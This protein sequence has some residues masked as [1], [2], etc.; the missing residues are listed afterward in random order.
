VTLE[1]SGD[2]GK[3]FGRGVIRDF[4]RLGEYERLCRFRNLGGHY[5][6]TARL[7]VA[8]ERDITLDGM[9]NVEVA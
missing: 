9:A 7:T 3:T 8:T 4:G 6:L 1:L 2:G 5:R